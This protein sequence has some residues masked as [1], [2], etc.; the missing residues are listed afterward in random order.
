MT[1]SSL[2][3]GGHP[4]LAALVGRLP[5]PGG[6]GV[7]GLQRGAVGSTYGVGE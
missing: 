1:L 7:G 6:A 3:N 4:V 2:K 5:K